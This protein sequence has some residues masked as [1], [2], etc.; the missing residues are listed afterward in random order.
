MTPL[1]NGAH[2]VYSPAQIQVLMNAS[3]E[4]AT[5][6]PSRPHWPTIRKTP[7]AGIFLVGLACIALVLTWLV[8][9][10]RTDGAKAGALIGVV[11]AHVTAGRA[12]G[13]V[14]AMTS[15]AFTRTETI[16]LASL[17]EG[18]IVSVFFSTFCLSFKKLIRI[19]WLIGAME[20][21]HRSAQGQRRRLLKWGIPGLIAF[22][23]FPFLMTGPVVGSA[24][25]FLLGMRPW[26]VM[27]V[28]MFGTVSAIVSWTFIGTP[29]A[30]L[31]TAAGEFI[32]LMVVSILVIVIVSF[33]VRRMREGLLQRGTI[34]KKGESDQ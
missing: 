10:S 9:L 30:E 24:I 22:V 2:N 21:V 31:A 32:P 12:Y 6:G 27:G 8:I 4:H 25:G 28:V 5:A 29:I 3:H 17:I 16:V 34:K 18:G 33:R 1:D 11:A 23:W 15:N 26:V 19:P 14:T 7:E 20:N 13:I